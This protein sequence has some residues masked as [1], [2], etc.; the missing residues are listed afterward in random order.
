MVSINTIRRME[1]RYRT[2]LTEYGITTLN[3]RAHFWAQLAHESNLVPRRENM[4]YS[5]SRL[6]AVFP[7]YFNPI[8]AYQYARKPEAIANRVY[9]NRM[10]NG[11]ESSGDGWKYRGGGLIQDTGKSR[12]RRL[13]SVLKVD[14]LKNPD[15]LLD[16]ANAIVA[17]LDFW[18][19]NNINRLADTEDGVSDKAIRAIT[20]VINGGFNGLEDR[21]NNFRILKISL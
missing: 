1:T 21:K 4:N 8:T 3:R 6:L 15:L 11:Q 12:Y 16:E 7:R 19:L 18:E 5:A 9:A 10:G 13:S 17:A 20:R 2:V 14:L